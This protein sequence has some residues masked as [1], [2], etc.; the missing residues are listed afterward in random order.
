MTKCHAGQQVIDKEG[1]S[2]VIVADDR[3]LCQVKYE[4]DQ[5]YS[6]IFWSLRPTAAPAPLGLVT[7]DPRERSA[8]GAPPSTSASP[9]LTVLRSIIPFP[10][11]CQRSRMMSTRRL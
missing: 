11:A 6:W 8:T 2:G 1:R 9:A 3:K 7:P 4:N 5:I 10:A